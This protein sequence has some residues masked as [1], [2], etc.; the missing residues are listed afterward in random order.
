MTYARKTVI[1][2]LLICILLPCMGGNAF[3]DSEPTISV[4]SESEYREFVE[5]TESFLWKKEESS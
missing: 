4:Q 5:K 3:A 1:T 2:F